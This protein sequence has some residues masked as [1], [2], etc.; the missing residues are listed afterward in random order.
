M[1]MARRAASLYQPRARHRRVRR[2]RRLR[3][4]RRPP[5]VGPLRQGRRNLESHRIVTSGRL[6]RMASIARVWQMR[7][8]SRL[9]T[10]INS[11]RRSEASVN[12]F[13]RA[14]RIAWA[15]LEDGRIPG[16]SERPITCH[17]LIFRA[18]KGT[19]LCTQYTETRLQTTLCRR[20]GHCQS[21]PRSWQGIA[22]TQLS[23]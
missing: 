13:T 12:L 18:S 6:S 9:R 11:T 17:Y 20:P 22:Q 2:R 23:R 5:M 10:S 21:V 8:T 14:T 1:A 3:R 4:R 15:R 16:M 7:P 19:M